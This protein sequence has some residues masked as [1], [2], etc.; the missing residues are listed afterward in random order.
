VMKIEHRR[1][2]RGVP[3]GAVAIACDLAKGTVD[4]GQGVGGGGHG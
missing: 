2:E 1:G 3:S 4:Y